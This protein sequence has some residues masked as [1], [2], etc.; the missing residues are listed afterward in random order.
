MTTQ[1]AQKSLDE[2]RDVKERLEDF[3]FERKLVYKVSYIK[4]NEWEYTY[5]TNKDDA[6]VFVNALK[7][8]NHKA[9]EE[10]YRC[11]S[12]NKWSWEMFI[13]V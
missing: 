1:E 6:M 4:D 12:L 7:D 11:V 3:N 10:I 8:Y 9:N 5:F 2:L 13:E